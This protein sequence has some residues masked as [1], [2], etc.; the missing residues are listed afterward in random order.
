ML[1]YLQ[2]LRLPT[3]F[4]AMADI[5]LG[6]LLTHDNIDSTNWPRFASLLIASC[7]LYLAGMV[8]NDVFDIEQDRAER[9]TRPIPSRRVSRTTA[10]VIGS[11][12][13]LIGAF[14]ANVTEWSYHVALALIAA[15][16]AYDAYLKRTP[17]GPLGMGACRFLNVLL[18]ASGLP[19][20]PAWSDLISQPAFWCALGL[21]TYIAGVTW[22]ARTEAKVSARGQ[23][24]GALAVSLGG[25]GLLGWLVVTHDPARANLVVAQLLL[26]MIAVN[27]TLRALSAIGDPSPERVQPLI[28]LMLLSY[29]MLCATLVYWHTGNGQYALA[30]ACLVIPALL[31][32]RLIPMT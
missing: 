11:V 3:V 12:L 22:F 30:T 10:V 9:P 14:A 4:T 24:I 13:I 32:K 26:G 23:L 19:M 31:L 7:G 6:F 21:G 25:I 5:F 17:L 28:P 29:V 8:F 16:F 15:I 18:G 2:L 27:V 1:A 20:A